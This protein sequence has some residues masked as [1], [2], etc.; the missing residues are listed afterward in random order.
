MYVPAMTER[1]PDDIRHER[2]ALD[3]A[4]VQNEAARDAFLVLAHTA[5]FAASVSF[6]GNLGPI[7]ALIWRQALILGW[8]ADV[9]GLL[10]LAASFAAARRAIDARRAALNEAE[11]PQSRLAEWLNAIALWSF[12]AALICLFAFVTAN[13]VH[14]DGGNAKSVAAAAA[15]QADPAD[16]SAGLAGGG[17]DPDSGGGGSGGGERRSATDAGAGG[18][19]GKTGQQPRS[20]QGA[21]ATG[22]A[23]GET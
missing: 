2:Q 4:H 19:N 12:P 13:V 22:K 10:A 16:R 14:A 21:G 3:A 11:A 20:G 23:G 1:S 8:T 15:G 17:S 18:E 7:S 9:T 5:L 6:V